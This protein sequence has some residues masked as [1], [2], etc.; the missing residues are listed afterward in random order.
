MVIL[1]T[2]SITAVLEIIFFFKYCRFLDQ[3]LFIFAQ[4]PVNL[5]NLINLLRK[6]KQTYVDQLDLK[7]GI[8]FL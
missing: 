2:Y 4:G 8:T 5:I 3:W 7:L 6:I 1:Y